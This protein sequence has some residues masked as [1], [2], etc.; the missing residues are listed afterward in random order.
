MAK[1]SVIRSVAI[2]TLK[3]HPRNPNKHPLEQV[4]ALAESAREF[5]QTRN[6]VVWKGLIIAGEGF[7][8]GAKKAGLTQVEIKDV[9]HWSEAKALAYMYA[10]NDL[11]KRSDLNPEGALLLL[12]LA[13][14]GGEHVPGVTD[15]ER[16]TMAKR[17]KLSK[18]E[19]VKLAADPEAMVNAPQA[20]PTSQ[21]GQAKFPLAI[22]LSAEQN[23]RWQEYKQTVDI[24]TDGAAFWQMFEAV[25]AQAVAESDKAAE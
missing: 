5:D 4:K 19:Q 25:T 22:V 1:K 9:S 15:E 24:K 7:W 20:G 6:I 13:E 14:K 2:D 10:D 18:R 3:P 17:A 11:A 16:L 21:A 12:E 8:R 23:R